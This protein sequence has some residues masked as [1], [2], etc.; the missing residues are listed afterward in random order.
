MDYFESIVKTLLEHEGYWVRQ[1]FKVNLTKA[2]KRQVGK[3]SIAR[4][5]IDLLAYKPEKKEVI[6][7]EVKSLLDSFGVRISDL[8]QRHEVMTGHYKLFTCE[9]YR[10]VVFARLKKDLIEKKMI[11]EDVSIRLGLAAGKVY[12]G[13]IAEVRSFLESKG[14][15]FWS[16]RDIYQRI[17]NLPDCGYENEPAIIT[18][19]ILHLGSKMKDQE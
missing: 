8:T 11:D 1:S 5:E 13:K 4:P 19:K 10:N 15:F 3:H 7:L 9:N 14:W 18:A 12:Q 16:P 6:A 17:K 2:E